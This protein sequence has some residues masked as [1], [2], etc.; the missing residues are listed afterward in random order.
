MAAVV[1]VRC[2]PDAL[3]GEGVLDRARRAAD[4]LIEPV[5]EERALLRVGDPAEQ[6]QPRGRQRQ[7]A[8]DQPGPQRRHHARGWRSA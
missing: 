6:Q 8:G 3:V 4:L 1:G 7:Q 2:G 5:E